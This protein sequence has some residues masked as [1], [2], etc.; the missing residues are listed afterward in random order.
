MTLCSSGRKATRSGKQLENNF[1][2][3]FAGR[4]GNTTTSNNAVSEWNINKM[5][6]FLLTEN[7]FVDELREIQ[8][9]SRRK[10]EKDS[11][12]SPIRTNRTERIV[13]WTGLEM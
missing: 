2:I 13:G 9:P 3:T 4:C 8:I 6:G 5:L 11:P 10:K 12:I 1:Q 7:D